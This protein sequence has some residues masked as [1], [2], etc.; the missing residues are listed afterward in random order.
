MARGL[1]ICDAVE[2][3]IVLLLYA[4]LTERVLNSFIHTHNPFSLLVLFS[5]GFVVLFVLLRR[6]ARH[7]SLRARD[8]ILAL[9]GTTAPLLVEPSGG[10]ALA[11]AWLCAGFML[12]GLCLQVA[13]KVTL[14]RGFGLIPANR[15]VIAKGPYRLLRHPMYAGYILTHIGFFLGNAIAFNGAIYLAEL[16]LQISRLAAEERLLARDPDYLLFKSQVRY[17]LIPGVF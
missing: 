15:G 3:V 8:W 16:A 6:R 13:A 4:F 5:E 9:A 7:I 11:P 2:R 14:G 10:L 1:V 17:R 12:L